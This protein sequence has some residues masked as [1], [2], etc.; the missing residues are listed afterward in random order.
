MTGQ[1]LPEDLSLATLQVHAD[2]LIAVQL[3]PDVSA[4]ISTTTTFRYPSDPEDLVTAAETAKKVDDGD[5]EYKDVPHIYSRYTQPVSSRAEAVLSSITGGHAVLYSSGLSAFHAAIIHLNPKTV[6]IGDGYHGC[7]GILSIFTRNWGLKIHTLEDLEHLDEHGISTKDSSI[8][9]GPG[10]VIHLESPVNPTGLA[11]DITYYADIAHKYGAK[12]MIDA[13]FAPPPLQD[14]FKWGVDL[15]L[16]SA[17]KYFGGHSDLLAGA[18]ITKDPKV[19]LEL[20]HDRNYI[21]TITASLESWLLLRSL[22]SYDLRIRRQAAS[23][24]EIVK[25]FQERRDEFPVLKVIYHASLQILE[26]EESGDPNHKYAWAKEQLP[27]GGGPVFAIE[28]ENEEI[29]KNIPSKTHLFHHATSLGGVESL[30]EWRAM[31]DP[32]VSKTLLRISIGIED[33]KDLINDLAQAFNN[34][35]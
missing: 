33:P 1:Q 25:Y 7:H 6:F 14:P 10:D 27:L 23:A 13:T 28:V 29:A 31:S 24:N 5:L 22:R 2:D 30:I 16:H 34:F 26:A 9:L 8:Q 4:P 20:K 17:T 3:G 18:L 32:T 11:F 12:I 35:V 21:G 19:E 15:I